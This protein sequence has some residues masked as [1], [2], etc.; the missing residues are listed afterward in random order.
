MTR[1]DALYEDI[2][3]WTHAYHAAHPD[4]TRDDLDIW[5][6]RSVYYPES[7]YWPG[8]RCDRCYAQLTPEEAAQC[9]VNGLEYYVNCAGCNTSQF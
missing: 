6:D 5:M 9:H 1:L 7:P 8:P 3:L 4:D 2:T